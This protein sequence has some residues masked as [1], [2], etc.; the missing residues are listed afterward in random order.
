MS[1]KS[2]SDIT[3]QGIGEWSE[4]RVKVPILLY[5]YNIPNI[6]IPILGYAI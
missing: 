5:Y 1:V 6:P 3:S 4:Q 2:I